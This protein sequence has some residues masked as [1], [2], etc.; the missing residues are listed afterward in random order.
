MFLSI[1]YDVFCRPFKYGLLSNG[2]I[3]NFPK[4]GM[5][6]AVLVNVVYLGI[7]KHHRDLRWVAPLAFRSFFFLHSIYSFM[8]RLSV[9][10]SS[11]TPYSFIYAQTCQFLAFLWTCCITPL[12]PFRF[13]P[14][15]NA[16]IPLFF[17][18]AINSYSQ[19]RMQMLLE[20]CF[21]SPGNENC[22]HLWGLLCL[23]SPPLGRPITRKFLA[24]MML[25]HM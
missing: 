15:M 17:C 21:I 2:S 12:C 6:Y 3:L 24:L 11:G 7:K 8:V 5:L 20:T 9:I 25:S 4:R 19:H 13:D 18:P 14:T 22:F 16:H 23:F 1:E 10:L